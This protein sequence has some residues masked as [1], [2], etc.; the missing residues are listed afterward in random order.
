[1]AVADG[2]QAGGPP[3]S[4]AAGALPTSNQAPSAAGGPTDTNGTTSH[5]GVALLV[6]GLVIA[7]GA[8]YL[9]GMLIVEDPRWRTAAVRTIRG[10]VA[11]WRA[12]IAHL[13]HPIHPRPVHLRRSVRG[14][15]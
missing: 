15:R 7:A 10:T 14:T 4:S 12:V 3:P 6:S 9:L 8:L 1:M 13:V 2:G 5:R 11:T